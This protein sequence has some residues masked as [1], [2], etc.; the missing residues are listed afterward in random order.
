MGVDV[1]IEYIADAHTPREGG[2]HVLAFAVEVEHPVPDVVEPAAPLRDL[3]LTLFSTLRAG[4][5]MGTGEPQ[6][7]PR[8]STK[9]IYP[10]WPQIARIRMKGM[11]V[12]YVNVHGTVALLWRVVK[13]CQDI[14]GHLQLLHQVM[15]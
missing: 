7:P 2:V 4:L 6:F 14:Q 13:Q 1:H 8:K 12:A 15:I 3:A 5:I 11:F 9:G 10:R